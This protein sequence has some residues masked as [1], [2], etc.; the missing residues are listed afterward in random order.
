MDTKELSKRL[1]RGEAWEAEVRSLT[2]MTY[3]VSL[4]LGD[5]RTVLEDD[6]HSRIFRNAIAAGNALA[7]A[8]M[9]TAWLTHQSVDDELSGS[10]TWQAGSTRTRMRLTTGSSSRD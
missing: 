6:G 4:A 2:P 8:G 5:H 3:M 10:A 1:E 9:Q 7:E